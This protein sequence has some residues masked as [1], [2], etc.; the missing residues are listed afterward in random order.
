LQDL[1]RK[2]EAWSSDREHSFKI[3]GETFRGRLGL[4]YELVIGYMDCLKAIDG[5]FQAAFAALLSAFLGPTE[6]DRFEAWRLAQRDA[7]N[8]LTIYEVTLIGA[9]VTE[10]ETNRPT[11]ASSD[12]STGR[13]T[14]GAGSTDGSSSQ[15]TE[16]APAPSLLAVS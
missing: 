9:A 10:E 13:E 8:P 5:Q 14:S 16:T 7:G 6:F 3:R 15:A 4:D 1:D 2:M 12:S 11:R